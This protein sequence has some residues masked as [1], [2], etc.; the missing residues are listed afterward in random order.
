MAAIA[1]HSKPDMLPFDAVVS[2]PPIVC[3]IFMGFVPMTFSLRESMV[4]LR[5][6]TIICGTKVPYPTPSMPS[7]DHNCRTM[8]VEAAVPVSGPLSLG[9][10]TIR[11]WN[12]LIFT[13]LGTLCEWAY[14]NETQFGTA[15]NMMYAT[16][17]RITAHIR[18]LGVME[19][20]EMVR[21]Y[22]SCCSGNNAL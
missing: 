8:K 9:S 21:F 7:S 15:C 11:V 18:R 3:S 4:T 13:A 14:D 5:G 1:W 20:M 6:L 10:A 16:R 17:S 19:F 12:R 22:Q 2:S